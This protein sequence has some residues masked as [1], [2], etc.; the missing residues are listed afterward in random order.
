MKK[1]TW[2]VLLSMLLTCAASCSQSSGKETTGETAPTQS[3]E[4]ESATE[5]ETEISDDLPDVTFDGQ[6]FRTYTRDCCEGV[7]INGLYI[8]ELTGDVVNDAVYSR[9]LTVEERFNVKIT[10]PITG[11]DGDCTA[12]NTAVSAGDDM[13][14][15]ADWHYKHLGDSAAKGYFVDMRSIGVLG[16]DKPWWYQNVNDAYSV[17]GHYYIMVGMYDTDNFLDNV[18]MYFNKNLL[19]VTFPDEDLYSVVKEG[20][21]TVD[22]FCTLAA[23]SSIDLDGDG[24]MDPAKDQFAYGQANGYSFVY[25]FAWQQPVTERDA[26]GYP[27]TCINTSH[28]TDMVEKLYLML[29]E[30]SENIVAESDAD[31]V[32]AFKEDREM[33]Q[34][35]SLKASSINFRDMDSDF[36]ILPMPK[37][38]EHQDGYYTH[39]TAHT[40]AVAIPV[41]KD[42]AGFVF[43]ET[44]LEALAAEGYK[45]VRPAVYDVALKS[46]Y[47]RDEVSYEMI[48]IVVRGRTADFAEIFDNW[49]LT[50]SLDH[51]TRQ[52]SKDWASFY[53]QKTKA[54][55]KAVGDAVALFMGLDK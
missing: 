8:E 34:L 4:T 41:T 24:V 5:T 33:F 48:D 29:F 39:A 51:L 9:N 3:T 42:E 15:V 52:K 7:H 37:W 11:A 50:Y 27:V 32:T 46:K 54:Q 25:Q 44:I 21:W 18:C 6:E 12:L 43:A 28:M 13:C 20:K 40:S 23:Q 14:D 47:T 49:G 17:G 53:Q 22:T 16:M 36:G 55:E 30:N 38:D 2:L 19:E 10:E 26:D 35:Q 1:W 31:A 45:Q